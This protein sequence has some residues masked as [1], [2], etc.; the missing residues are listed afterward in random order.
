AAADAAPSCLA[1]VVDERAGTISDCVF[2]VADA[3]AYARPPYWNES[4][5]G[6]WWGGLDPRA[7]DTDGDGLPDA[8]EARGWFV[9]LTRQVGSH[10][11][12]RLLVHSDPRK[13]D[14]DGDGLADLDE[15]RGR[16]AIGDREIAFPPTDPSNPD[17]D[18]DG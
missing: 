8:L 14:S 15:Y 2:T 6:P 9:N 5:S 4:A 12:E 7:T 10:E 3:Y 11:P 13:A 17:S 16:V 1:P 18:H